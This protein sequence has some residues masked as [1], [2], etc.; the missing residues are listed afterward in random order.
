L[1]GLSLNRIAMTTR[2]K[3]LRRGIPFSPEVAPLVSRMPA[4]DEYRESLLRLQ[5]VWDSLSMLGQMSGTLPDIAATRSAFSALTET[6]L[7]SLGRC[8]LTNVVE[9]MRNR[10]QVAIDILV[11]NLFE[12]TADIGFL[13]TDTAVREFMQASEPDEAQRRRL[14]LRFADY[15]AKYS[16][17]DDIVVLAADGRVLARLNPSTQTAPCREAWLVQA[18]AGA[19]YVEHYGPSP[20][21][22]GRTALLYAAAIRSGNQTLGVMCLSFRLADEMRGVFQQLLS[23]GDPA[24]IALVDSQGEVLASS[25]RWQLPLGAV[26]P[27]ADPARS[28]QHLR[29]AGREYLSVN[30]AANAYEGYQGPGWSAR[31]MVPIDQAFEPR[32]DDSASAPESVLERIDT[33]ALFN[34]ELRGIPQEAL[35]IQRDLS[36]VLW[37]GKLQPAAVGSTMAGSSLGFAATL[38]REVGQTGERIRQVFDQ[39]THQLQLSTLSAVFEQ[40]RHHARLAIDIM[41]RNLYERANDCRWWALDGVLR[42]VLAQPAEQRDANAAAA[43]L[44]RINGLYT[45]YSLLVLFDTQGE[46]VAVSDPAA[47]SW[48]GQTLDAPW[49]RETLALRDSQSYAASVH[50]PSPLYGDRA[51]YVFAAAL[52]AP[53]TQA[54]VV[55]GI[56]IVFD[57]GPQFEAMLQDSLPQGS[58]A[59]SV[60]SL[61]ITRSG[62]VVASSD[63]RWPAG[64]PAPMPP[65]LPALAR[66][67]AE[68]A[69]IDIDGTAYVAGYGMSGGYREYRSTGAAAPDDVAGLMLLRLGGHKPAAEPAVVS[70][71][72]AVPSA[73]HAAS[74]VSI[75][76]F[77]CD[78]QWLGI[79]ASAALQALQRPRLATIANAPPHL[80][81]MT[82][83][84]GQLLPV[85]DVALLRTRRPTT[86][87]D[88]PVVVAQGPDGQRFAL[89]VDELG[90]VFEVPESQLQPVQH[91]AHSG[92]RLVRGHQQMLTLLDMHK[93]I[94]SSGA[95]RLASDLMA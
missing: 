62:T 45:V 12:R 95:I 56:A 49:V 32:S 61:F 30:A 54:R 58:D 89:R 67:A 52:R 29:F 42:Q 47:A 2:K 22:G 84:E 43:V 78:G 66:G 18:L 41:D 79:P 80:L 31:V 65:G 77:L 36:R 27:P 75:A 5:G 20:T 8:L 24:V 37:N 60:A 90:P 93:L 94:V 40:A 55:G 64:S 57:G 83:F 71:E 85:V 14:E 74:S 73:T 7:D 38:L 26:L 25:D 59:D 48:R 35:R 76:S 82:M 11:R 70:F 1:G 81:G 34:A 4:V 51:T 15:A 21:M 44:A 3:I 53:D 10:G 69:V 50:T 39:A 33:Q 6:L 87:I 23:A 92:E 91:S 88:A 9:H 63:A 28:Y 86:D 72:P 17:Y 68:T 46:V 13:S 19:P 16:V